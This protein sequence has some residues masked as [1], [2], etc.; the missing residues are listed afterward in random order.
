VLTRA[1]EL[2][3]V[4]GTP[5][6]PAGRITEDLMALARLSRRAFAASVAVCTAGVMTAAPA[7]AH[8]GHSHDKHHSHLTVLLDDLSSPKGLTIAP[9]GDPVVGQGAFGGPGPVLEYVLHGPDRGTTI[10]L[11]DPFRYGDVAAMAASSTVG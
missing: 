1:E 2:I 4:S 7:G 3:K 8:I 11:T 10:P 6:G 5:A 9:N